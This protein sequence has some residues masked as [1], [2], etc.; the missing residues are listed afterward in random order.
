MVGWWLFAAGAVCLAGFLGFAVTAP[1]MEETPYG[2]RPVT[3][4]KR[5]DEPEEPAAEPERQA[6]HDRFAV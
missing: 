4:E 2:L 6:R 3:D 5:G 1:L